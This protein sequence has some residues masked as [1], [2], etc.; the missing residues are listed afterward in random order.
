MEELVYLSEHKIIDTLTETQKRFINDIREKGI[1]KALELLS[2]HK[3]GD[4]LTYPEEVVFT[5][6]DTKKT[7]YLFEL[8]LDKKFT[9]PYKVRTK[10]NSVSYTNLRLGQTYYWRIDEGEIC[11]FE[12]AEGFVRF[13]KADGALNIRDVGGN[14]IKQGLIYRGSEIN[15]E[16]KLT[17][18]GKRVLR[19]QLGIKAELDLR[20]ECDGTKNVSC[21][22]EE[23]Q[24]KYLPYRPY[25]ELFE[26]VHRRSIVEIM[27][28]L[29]DEKNY[30]IYFHC[31]GGAD[32][33]GMIALYLRALLGESD[34]DIFIDYELTSLSTYA[35]G[36][37]EGVSALG[38]RSHVMDYFVEFMEL[39]KKY[40]N[41]LSEMTE[42]SLIECGVKKETL[43]KIR[44]ILGK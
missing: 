17:E 3:N 28:F 22:G 16:Y 15:R 33:T 40:G 4:E 30:P 37:A 23:V 43:A 19:E 38:Y 11:S 5:W 39:F 2:P 25:K 6:E 35:A 29:S 32:R 7:D 14:K 18:D 13:I 44:S 24:Y 26:D 12:T 34:E 27:E 8:S 42:A 41:T 31:Y 21:I 1:S 20:G 10:K 9:A 36:C